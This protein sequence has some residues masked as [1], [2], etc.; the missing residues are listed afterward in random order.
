L[1]PHQNYGTLES[2][3][4]AR[5]YVCDQLTQQPEYA[6]LHQAT[7]AFCRFVTYVMAPT[8]NAFDQAVRLK[9]AVILEPN[10]IL[11]RRLNRFLDNMTFVDRLTGPD[12]LQQC[13]FLITEVAMLITPQTQAFTQLS[14]S[15]LDLGLRC[16]RRD[17][18]HL[19][20]KLIALRNRRLVALS[21]SLAPDA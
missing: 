19:H 8:I 1:I 14:P 20:Q 15:L 4:Y 3:E 9:V 2:I 7:H 17:Y 11:H 16:Q 6:A 18:H 10:D 5:V 21:P 13:D 12:A